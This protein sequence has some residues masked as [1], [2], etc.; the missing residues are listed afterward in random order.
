MGINFAFQVSTSV[1]ACE[2]GL[3]FCKHMVN[4]GA[5][6]NFVNVQVIIISQIWYNGTLAI[7]QSPQS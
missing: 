5:P 3:F 6:E 2:N 4:V 7:Q 1:T